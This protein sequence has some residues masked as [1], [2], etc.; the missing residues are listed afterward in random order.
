M[1]D[2]KQAAQIAMDKAVDILGGGAATIEEIERDEYK[3]N[4]AWFITLGFPKKL[5]TLSPIAA[6]TTAHL[7]VQYK[8]FII[9]AAD[10]ELFA[11]KL[12]EPVAG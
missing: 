2:A 3:G 4:D 11:I 8:R 12:R 10:G 7:H 5:E 6:L 9:S 1:I